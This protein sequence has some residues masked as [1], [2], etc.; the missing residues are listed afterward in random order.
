[1][2][3][4]AIAD[5][6]KVD[7]VVFLSGK[8]FYDL[9]KA[10]KERGINDQVALIRLEVCYIAAAGS[11][12]SE[13]TRLLDKEFTP[14]PYEALAEQISTFGQAASFVWAQEESENAGAFAFVLPRLQQLLPEGTALKY[15]GRPPLAAAATGIV[16]ESKREAE[17]LV[18]A[19]L[20][21]P[22]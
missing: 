7:R 22:M 13:L 12:E 2:A 14:F 19:V 18:D 8:L 9:A 21:F 5:P 6:S 20:R 3:D 11:R 4:E 10:R 1:L 16:S 15:A 17:E